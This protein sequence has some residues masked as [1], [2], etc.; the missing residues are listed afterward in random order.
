MFQQIFKILEDAAG[1]TYSLTR[2]I[3]GE[4]LDNT[5]DAMAV[6][7]FRDSAGNAV[8][9]QLN[10]EGAIVVSSDS[11]TPVGSVITHLVAAQTKDQEDLAGEVV[12]EISENYGKI[13][14]Q[15]VSTR[16]S[17][18]RLDLVTDEGGGGEAITELGHGFA[19]PG[20]ASSKLCSPIKEFTT[21]AVGIQKLRLYMT[22]LDKASDA[23]ANL[24][25][26]KFS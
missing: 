14:C 18:W 5:V 19:G 22:P 9:P 17:L 7:V 6:F 12:L 11:G 2:R 15:V 8:F 25:V 3:V 16:D 13:E 24:S 21:T 4:V 20:E 26:F 1:A 10:G 23:Y